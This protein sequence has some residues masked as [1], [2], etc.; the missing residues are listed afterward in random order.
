MTVEEQLD[1]LAD[2]LEP[3]EFQAGETTIRPNTGQPLGAFQ[4]DVQRLRRYA[5]D[6]HFEI[7][8]EHQEKGSSNR[9]SMRSTFE[10]DPR[11]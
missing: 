6:G 8:R 10:W 1:K 2:S 3:T 7:K 11:A 4:A 9:T 5:D